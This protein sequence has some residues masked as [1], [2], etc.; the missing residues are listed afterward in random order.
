MNV[1]NWRQNGRQGPTKS[2][3]SFMG[4]FGTDKMSSVELE[5]TQESP[6]QFVTS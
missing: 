3:L 1:L 2:G 5:E 6:G 4:G